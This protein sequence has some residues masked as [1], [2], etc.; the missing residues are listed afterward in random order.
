LSLGEVDVANPLPKRG[1]TIMKLHLHKRLPQ[2]F[3]EEIFEPL[4][5]HHVNEKIAITT[6]GLRPSLSSP[7]ISEENA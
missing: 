4:K 7:R 2:Y 3:A 1:S 5:S 6:L